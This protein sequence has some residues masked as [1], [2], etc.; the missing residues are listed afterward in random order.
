[1]NERKYEK[2]LEMQNKLISRQSEQI[3]DLEQ[4]VRDLQLEIEEKN[5]VI[6]SIEPMREEMAKHI[7][8]VKKRKVEFESLTNEVR[9][10]KEVLNETVY[11]G[12]WN[13][14]KLLIK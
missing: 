10:M 3:K 5:E 11:K 7:A 13:L 12:R 6:F 8:E 9:K 1:M 2:R 14:V 4:Q